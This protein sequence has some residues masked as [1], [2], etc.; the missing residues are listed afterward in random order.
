MKRSFILWAIAGV[1]LAAGPVRGQAPE[2]AQEPLPD[3]SDRKIAPQDLLQIVI[4]G[5]SLPTE[6]RVSA[7]GTI[8]FPFLEVV[9]VKGLTPREVD[10]KLEG[11]LSKDYFVKPEVLVDIKEYRQD[12]VRMIGQV[13]R[14]GPLTLKPEQQMDILDALSFAGG[15][16]RLAKGEV[17][18]IRDGQRQVFS[19]EKLKRETDPAKKV[20][21]RPGDIVEVKERIW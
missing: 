6:Y 19:I 7:S 3:L 1:L 21:L 9:E 15:T 17:E 20:W 16:T 10:L 13:N 8:N 5:E 2:P 18:F 14:P 11:L 4:V 12:F